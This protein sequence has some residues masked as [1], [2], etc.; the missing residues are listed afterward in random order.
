MGAGTDPRLHRRPRGADFGRLL[1]TTL[2]ELAA[3]ADD[4]FDHKDFGRVLTAVADRPDSSFADYGFD[5]AGLCALRD[6][7]RHW[8]QRLI[9]PR[10]DHP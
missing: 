4:G 8:G 7:L 1:R 6:L 2:L 3:R 5:P 9:E 10:D